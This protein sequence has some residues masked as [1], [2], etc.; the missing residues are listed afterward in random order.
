MKMYIIAL[1]DV[2]LRFAMAAVAHALLAG[3]F[4]SRTRLKFV[5]GWAD[6]RTQQNATLASHRVVIIPAMG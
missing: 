6:P 3:Y 4:S 5:S 1:H 2:P